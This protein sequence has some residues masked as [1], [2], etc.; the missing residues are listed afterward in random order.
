LLRRRK[1]KYRESLD[2][3]W[4][5]HIAH[6]HVRRNSRS[7]EQAGARVWS[8][9]RRRERDSDD[10]CKDFFISYTHTDQHWAEWIAWCLEQAGYRVVIQAWDFRPGANF[11][12]E[13][14][15]AL[16]RARRMISVLSPAYLLSEY[17]FAEWAEM[18][19]RDPQGRGQLLVPVQIQPCKVV[20]LLGPIVHINLVG[21]SEQDARERLLA[22]VQ[23]D[24]SHPTSVIY[25][26]FPG[27]LPALWNVPYRRNPLFTGRKDL[28][29]QLE[30]TLHSGQVTALSPSKPSAD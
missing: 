12:Y 25:P 10:V 24:R 17:A 21:V 30:H 9:R 26:D 27:A 3:L 11:V 29:E 4:H 7:R 15:Q 16:K 20:G 28:L 1:P 5:N 6:Y 22:G 18:F 2:I 13:M 8:V 19:R 23:Q 14:D